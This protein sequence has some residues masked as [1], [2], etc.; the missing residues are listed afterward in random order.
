MVVPLSP[1]EDGDGKFDDYW[2]QHVDLICQGLQKLSGLTSLRFLVRYVI[3]RD[4]LYNNMPSL[5]QAIFSAPTR[6]PFRL[7]YFWTNLPLTPLLGS[8]I[9]SQPIITFHWKHPKG[10]ERKE[11]DPPSFHFHPSK[12]LL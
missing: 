4:G 7:K 6:F 8:F 1:N 2:G 12:P 10:H 9:A 3:P 5:V 11:N